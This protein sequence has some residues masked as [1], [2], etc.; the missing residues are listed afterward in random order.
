MGYL[1]AMVLFA[2]VRS[3]LENI[4]APEH[5]KGLPLTLIAA[6]ILSASFVGFT[7]VVDGLFM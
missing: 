2:G 1:L 4:D 7:G 6:S 3:R 5:F